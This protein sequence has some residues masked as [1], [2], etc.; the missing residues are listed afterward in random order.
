MSDTVHS[1][2][3]VGGVVAAFLLLPLVIG[4]MEHKAMAHMQVRMGPMYAGGFHGWLQLVADGVKF[5]QKEDVIP[6]AAD[7]TVFKL[8]PFA[9]LIPYLVVL[10]LIPVGPGRQV[11]QPLE[12]GLFVALALLGVG[13]IGMLMAAWAS[14]NKFALLGGLRGAAQLMAYELPMVL[15][16]ASVAMQAGTLSLTGIAVEWKP[17]W[18]GSQLIGFAIFMIAGLAELRR[19]PFDMPIAESELVFGFLTEY[20]GMR[21]AFFLLAEYAGILVLCALATVLYLGGWRLPF[22]PDQLAV[23]GTLIKVFALSFVVIW[24]RVSVPRLRED[25]LQRLAWQVLVPLALAQVALT[26]VI[27]VTR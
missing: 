7:R 9:A 18:L 6:S 3:G 24:V 4:F 15:A 1:I 5:I 11:A 14:A 20:T 19:P 26:A 12:Q 17:W 8:A 16:A 25:Q 27:Q 10:T 2:L 22:L 21:F 23:V 13:V